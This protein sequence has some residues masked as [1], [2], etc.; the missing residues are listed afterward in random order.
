VKPRSYS[1]RTFL[2]RTVAEALKDAGDTMAL[3]GKWHPGDWLAERLPL[4]QGFGH[5]YGHYGWGID[6]NNHTPAQYAH[7]PTRTFRGKW[8]FQLECS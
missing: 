3:A 7:H 2:Q 1:R 4:G 5:Q 6:Y 8:S